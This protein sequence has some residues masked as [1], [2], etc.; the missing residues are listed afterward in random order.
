MIR[1]SFA[2]IGLESGVR[3][4][5]QSHFLLSFSFETHVVEDVTDAVPELPAF[6][7]FIVK[8]I[9]SAHALLR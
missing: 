6:A 8:I 7:S 1:F 2:L 9:T 5:D 4:L 3:F